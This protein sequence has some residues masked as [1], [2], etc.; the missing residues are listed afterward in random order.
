M[1]KAATKRVTKKGAKTAR[2]PGPVPFDAAMTEAPPEPAPALDAAPPEAP[3]AARPAH[4]RVK[5]APPPPAE[6]KLEPPTHAVESSPEEE[7]P[8]RPAK[9]PAGGAMNIAKLQAMAMSDLNH[10]AKDMGIENFGTMR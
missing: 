7:P 6:M 5:S 3:S 4:S 2:P 10:S 9:G 1:P 8:G